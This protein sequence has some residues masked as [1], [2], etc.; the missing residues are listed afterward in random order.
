[1]DGALRRE[2]A[3][4]ARAGERREVQ[5][6]GAR[7]HHAVGGREHGDELGER[8]RAR[9]VDRVGGQ[10]VEPA[11]HARALRRRP[12]HQH[13]EAG[14]RQRVGE[15]AVV[16]ERPLARAPRRARMQHDGEPVAGEMGRGGGG[17]RD[18]RHEPRVCGERLRRRGGHRGDHVG[19]EQRLGELHVELGLVQ[20]RRAAR[21]GDAVGA[22]GPVVPAPARADAAR[23]PRPERRP[24]DARAREH[25]HH[26]VGPRGAE[27]G[28]RRG[29]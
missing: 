24:R 15:G 21:H 16:R 11:P 28:P 14:G 22:G 4:G 3:Q 12:G 2:Q 26:R 5:R 1:V 25:V 20:R 23:D 6:A 27:T 17:H 9:Q 10:R 19:A 29:R 8:E 18:A 13:A 7:R